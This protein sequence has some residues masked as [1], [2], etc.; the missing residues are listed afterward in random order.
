[1]INI[2]KG[3]SDSDAASSEGTVLRPMISYAQN[4]EDVTLRRAFP[5]EVSGFYVDVGAA[6]PYYDSVTR[7]FYGIGWSG[8]NIEPLRESFDLLQM[9]RPRDKNLNV[10]LGR[11][12]GNRTFYHVSNHGLSTLDERAAQAAAALG[13][14]VAERKVQVRTL[15]DVFAEFR[16][17]RIDFLKVDA[18][19]A[20]EDVLEGANWSDFRPRVVLIEAT[21][22]NTQESVH[23]SWESLLTAAGYE[24]AW[25]DCLNRFYVA[26]EEP[27]LKT[28]LA[29]PP[30]YFDNFRLA[31]T[32][33]FEARLEEVSRSKSAL[34]A[35]TRDAD[36]G[37]RRGQGGEDAL[38]R[39]Q[40]ESDEGAASADRELARIRQSR[41]YRVAM[42]LTNLLKRVGL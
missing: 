25:F 32:V 37:P 34:D 40:R 19:G 13:H 17:S 4:F 12:A 30:S 27:M 36:R 15:A 39:R 8:I 3:I 7:W 38:K 1:M 26:S 11:E 5:A 23:D 16:P 28:A 10:A 18:E 21:R 6:D 2:V 22:P 14:T 9:Q 35:V 33:E 42:R 24:F 20:E 41:T 31:R 29:R